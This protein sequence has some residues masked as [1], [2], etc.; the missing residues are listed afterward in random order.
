MAARVSAAIFCWYLRVNWEPQRLR[1]YGAA[2]CASLCLLVQ[3]IA[4]L[5]EAWS[6]CH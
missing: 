1:L 5:P 4:P 2:G 6:L 3:S